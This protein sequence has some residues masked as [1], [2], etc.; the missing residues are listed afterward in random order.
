M[1]IASISAVAAAVGV[2]VGVVFTVLEVRNLVKARKTDLTMRLASAWH[3][4]GLMEKWL[5]V[6]NLEFKDYSDFEKRY[7]APHSD[8][9]EYVALYVVLEHF[10]VQGYLLHKE[11][12]DFDLA[13]ISPV[14]STW[15]KTKPIIEGFR[16]QRNEPRL[17]EWFEYLY[18]E[19]QRR[20]R[21]TATIQ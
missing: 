10:E 14:S 13:E 5:K 8:N 12:I 6:M 1:D 19:M 9:P 17:L 7:G 16:E 2:I 15:R 20:E 4:G 11:M 18:N 3:T 21:Q